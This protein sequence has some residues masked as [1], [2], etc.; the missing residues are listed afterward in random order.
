MINFRKINLIKLKQLKLIFKEWV[1]NKIN[2]NNKAKQA[3][4]EISKTF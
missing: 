3:I 2:K 1:N 4:K